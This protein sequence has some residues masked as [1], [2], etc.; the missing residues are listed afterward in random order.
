MVVETNKDGLVRERELLDHLAGFLKASFIYPRNNQRVQRGCAQVF[1][2]LEDVR[3]DER[4][5]VVTIEDEVFRVCGTR[6]EKLSPLAKW[7]KEVCVK[8]AIAGIEVDHGV[9]KSSLLDF[10][11]LLRDNYADPGVI[12]SA[13]WSKPVESITPIELRFSGKHDSDEEGDEATAGRSAETDSQ[14]Q[15]MQMLV[16]DRQIMGKLDRLQDMLNEHLPDSVDSAQMNILDPIS[17]AL[18][19]EAVLNPK[20]ACDLVDEI[21]NVC[22]T[23][24]VSM[25]AEKKGSQ[26]DAME[27]II[28][29]VGRR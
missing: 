19:V 3:Q 6:I 2:A 11:E 23:R 29:D 4:P 8:T 25:I 1:A 15:V 18:P 7:L 14:D 5:V 9:T 17:K 20:T 28:A 22:G 10:S 26:R 21:L 24:V 13:L 16:R 12:F 27:A